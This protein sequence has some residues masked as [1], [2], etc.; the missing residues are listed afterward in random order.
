VP[1]VKN[2]AGE[3]MTQITPEEIRQMTADGTISGG[4]IPK[5][6]TALM[7]LDKGTRAVTILDGRI[8]NACLIE[9]FTDLGAGSQIRS[10][11]P[12]VKSRTP[13]ADRT[14][15]HPAL[16]AISAMRGIPVTVPRCHVPEHGT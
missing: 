6:E 14:R 7:A 10:T 11:A 1:G 4:M 8:P 2:A 15:Q 9:L 5:T 12:R 13:G 16:G 3:V